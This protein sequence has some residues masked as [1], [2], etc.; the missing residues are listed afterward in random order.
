MNQMT[1]NPKAPAIGCAIGLSGSLILWLIV[2]LILWSL[3]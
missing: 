3:T 2:G 1:E